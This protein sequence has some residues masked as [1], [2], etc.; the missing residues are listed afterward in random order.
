MGETRVRSSLSNTKLIV[1]VCAWFILWAFVPALLPVSVGTLVSDHHTSQLLIDISVA[2]ILLVALAATHRKFH[3]QLFC[4]QWTIWLYALPCVALISIPLRVGFTGDIF[5][6]PAWLYVLMITANVLTQQ[7][8]TFGLL[9]SYLE[10][11]FSLWP[12]VAITT[13]IFYLGHGIYIPDKFAIV[14]VLPVLFIFAVGFIFSA[15]RAYLKTLH[16][17]IALHLFVYFLVI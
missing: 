12:T 13:T 8:L 2:A 9:Q 14:Y 7:Y 4:R 10:Q 11:R 17:N 16:T 3:S 5:G 15:I 6:Q 1:V